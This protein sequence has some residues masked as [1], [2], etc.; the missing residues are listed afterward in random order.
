[1][2]SQRAAGQ[3][4]RACA[5]VRRTARR[6]TRPRRRHRR[7]AARHR[8]RRGGK[9]ARDRRRDRQPRR[10]RT[11]RGRRRRRVRGS[12]EH[13]RRHCRNSEN[14]KRNPATIERHGSE[15]G[16]VALP[17]FKIGCSPFIRGGS[18]R[19]R[20]A[21]AIVTYFL[22]LADSLP[23]THGHPSAAAALGRLKTRCGLLVSS[24]KRGSA[25]CGIG[26]RIRFD[27]QSGTK[28][29]F[30]QADVAG[31]RALLRIFRRELDA[32]SFS[33]KLEH[34]APHGAAVEE[35]LDSTL[36][37]DVP[38]TLI[39]QKA[40]ACP[41]WHSRSPP[42]RTPGIIP[43]ELSRIGRLR[44]FYTIGTRAGRVFQLKL[45]WEIGASL[46]SSLPYVKE[47]PNFS[48]APT[49]R[50]RRRGAGHLP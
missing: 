39:D 11:A 20:G 1:A 8:M 19:L 36:V 31:A 15:R 32:L 40:C 44:T 6:S 25:D 18:V 24:W 23:A 17:V 38:E 14:V 41:G 27:P 47:T 30:D 9:R 7:Y 4:R 2:G 26:L 50:A 45:S 12:L 48:G 10:R 29:S 49:A 21:S 37:A 43:K 35:V 5:C 16:P 42:F 33:K 22:V 46:G 34:R 3:S 13:R 28:L